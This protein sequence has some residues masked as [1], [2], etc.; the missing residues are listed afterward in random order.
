MLEQ[1][2]EAVT[3]SHSDAEVLGMVIVAVLTGFILRTI[4]DQYKGL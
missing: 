3:G 2:S 1:V 4:Y